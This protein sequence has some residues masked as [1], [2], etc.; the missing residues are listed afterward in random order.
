MKTKIILIVIAVLGLAFTGSETMKNF[1][2][3]GKFE[4]DILYLS[5]NQGCDWQILEFTPQKKQTFV[6][7]YGASGAKY[8]ELVNV[9]KIS[10]FQFSVIKTENSLE[11]KAI[12]GVNWLTV[13]A[14]C[15]NTCSFTLD[16]DGIKVSE[17]S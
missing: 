5:C 12:D 13:S 10:N 2:I 9:K 14:G 16:N 1:D 11:F 3:S 7:A 17:K 15:T 8:P 4:N 6:N